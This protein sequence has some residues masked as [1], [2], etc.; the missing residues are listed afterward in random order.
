MNWWAFAGA[1]YLSWCA[2]WWWRGWWTRRQH[3][4]WLR[5][6]DPFNENGDP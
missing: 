2:G 3:E 6:F 5:S 4:T 1:C